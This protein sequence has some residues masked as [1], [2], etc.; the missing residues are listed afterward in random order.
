M[1]KRTFLKILPAVGLT[2]VGIVGFKNL[3]ASQKTT[4]AQA[5][6][7]DEPPR[8][9]NV[10][11][12][13]QT[14]EANPEEVIR[15][16]LSEADWKQVLTPNQFAILRKEAT[17]PPG[18][19]PLDNEKRTGEFV[20]SGCGLA[21]FSST[22]K[23]DSRT[24]WPSF[25]DQIPGRIGTKTDWKI[26]YP[27]QEYHC[28]RCGGHQGHIFKDGPQPTGLRYCNNGLALEFKPS[29]TSSKLS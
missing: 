6:T 19:S 12:D 26:G 13:L 23:Y 4:P 29:D 10:I 18:S 7:G 1:N 5:T 27:R 25:F 22:T 9:M 3:F 21:L 11:D 24:G 15:F 2:A 16:E 28:Q 8:P 17:E 20:C 14:L